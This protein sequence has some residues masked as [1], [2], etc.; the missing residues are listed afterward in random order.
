MRG[1]D[2]NKGL[3]KLHTKFPYRFLQIL[4]QMRQCLAGGGNFF[5]GSGLLFC[6]R[7][8][9]AGFVRH[10]QGKIFDPPYRC[11]ALTAFRH[12]P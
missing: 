9:V 3:L 7:R 1:M 2:Y 12:R 5:H 10:R 11:G 8:H 6:R 4:R